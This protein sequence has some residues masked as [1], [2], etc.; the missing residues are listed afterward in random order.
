MQAMRE[1]MAENRRRHGYDNNALSQPSTPQNTPAKEPPAR[2]IAEHPQD[3]L[4]SRRK[5]Q[6]D[7][8]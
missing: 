4:P 2:L 8:A 5:R 1:E 3:K 7:K 6:S